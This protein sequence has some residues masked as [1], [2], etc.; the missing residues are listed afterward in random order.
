M[1]TPKVS[2]SIITWNQNDYIAQAIDS[3]LG[4]ETNFEVEIWIGDDYSTD[5]TREILKKYRER[6]PDKIFL[7]LQ[8]ERPSGI[9]GRLNNMT[10]LASCRGQY[11]AM[12]DGDDFWTSSAKL[13]RQ[14]DV[15]DAEPTLSGVAHDAT[16]SYEGE[17]GEHQKFSQMVYP[18]HAGTTLV[19]LEDLLILPAFQTSTFMFRPHTAL[20]LPEWFTRLPAADWGL[21]AL[22]ASRGSIA[23]LPEAMSVYRRH[24]SSE[25]A[26]ISQ[27][28]L[29]KHLWRYENFRMLANSFPDKHRSK[30]WKAQ[31]IKNRLW[32]A[33]EN[34]EYLSILINFIRLG[35]FYDRSFLEKLMADPKKYLKYALNIK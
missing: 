5:G 1:R 6:Y 3:V 10:N 30:R 29:R 12:L 8:P 11:I 28:S 20:P 16:I 27:V 32:I 7:N 13:Q 4:Q 35:V 14:A 23:I 22:V 19:T 25:T 31:D 21:F 24:S 33:A 2:V 18:I 26:K 15:L 34:G 17:V 9:P